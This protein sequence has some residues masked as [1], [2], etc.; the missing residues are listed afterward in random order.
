MSG[1]DPYSARFW[2]LMAEDEEKEEEERRKK[3]GLSSSSAP[4]VSNVSNNELDPYSARFWEL[5]NEEEEK[6]QPF[7]SG[8]KSPKD[9]EEDDDG[10]LDF[11]DKGS[12]NIFGGIAATIGDVGLSATKGIL[13]L[14][15]GAGDLIGYGLA[16]I[17]DLFGADDWADEQREKAKKNTVEDGFKSMSD[18]LDKYSYLG[19]TSQAIAQGIGQVGGIILTGGLGSAAGLGAVGTTALTTGVMGATSMGSGMSEAY[20][21]GA[22]DEDALKYGVIKGFVD[23]GTELIFGGLGKTVKAVGLSKG[24]SSLD[25]VFARKLSEKVAN[26]TAKQF[27]QF[28]VK[29][30]AEGVEEVLAGIGSAVGKKLTYADDEE[31]GQLLQDENLLEQFVV[32]A[33]T[34][35][36]AQS[37]YVPGMK[38]GSLRESF[39]TGRDFISGLSVNEQKVVDSVFEKELAEKEKSGK[40]T[41]KAKNKLYEQ[42]I[43]DMKLGR[44]SI[45]DIEGALGGESYNTYKT[46]SEQQ[47]KLTEQ[48]KALTEE[49]ESIRNKPNPTI[50]DSERLAEARAEQAK[51]Q[52]QLKELGVK[53]QDFKTKL[54]ETVDTLTQS[55]TYLRESYNERAKRRQKFEADVSK[56]DAKQQAAVQRAI[57][58]GILNNTRR[59]HEIVDLIAK[60]EAD[61]GVSFDFANN[62]KLKELGFTIE[63]GVVNGVLTK[64]GV[65]LNMNSSNVARSVIGHEITHVLQGTEL[66]SELQKAIKQYA[67]TKGV[68]DSRY[69]ELLELYTKKDAD[70]KIVTDENGNTIYLTKDG[71]IEGIENEVVADLVGEYLFTDTDFINEL[72][73]KHRN[74]FQKIYDE[75]KYLL[76]VI[77]AGS[78]EAR[79]LEKVKHAFD[80]AYKADVKASESNGV[81]FSFGVTQNDINNYVDSAYDNK[82]S[83]DYK[84]YAKVSDRLLNDVAEEIDLNGYSHALRD[85]DIRHIRNSHGENTAEKY[86][87]TKE[88]IKNIPWIVENYDKAVVVKRNDG[89]VGIIYVKSAENG[90]VY[91][92][93]Q[94]TSVYGNEP[95]LVNKQMI[96]TGIDDIPDLPGLKEA[97]TKKQSEIEFLDDLK[98][99]PKVYAQDVY[100]SHSDNKIAQQEENV[101]TDTSGDVQFSLSKPVEKTKNLVALHNLTQEK[102]LKS[103]DVGGL[104]M[105]SIAVT[106]SDIPHDNFGE[107][108]LIFG[109]DTVDP[110]ANKKNVVYSADAWTPTF[111]QVEYEAD[112]NVES[113]INNKINDLKTRVDDIF[114][115]DLNRLKYNYEYNLNR[116]G[117]EEG[118][119][120]NAMENYGLKAAYLEEQGQHIDKVTKQIEV[121]KG[122]SSANEAKYQAIAD[123]LGT[124]SAEEIGKLPFDEVREKYGA[125]LEDIYPGMT[126]SNIRISG[127]FNQVMAYLNN[128]NSGPVYKT[129]TDE[130]AMRKAVDD[131]LDAD[132]FE[133]WTRNLFSGI[134]KDSGIYNQKDLFTPSGNRRSFKQTH[135]PFT[136]ENIVKAMA[137][138]NNG[139][140]KNVAGFNGIKS[141]RAGTAERFKSI[142]AMHKSEGRLQHLTQEEADK[143]N[144]DLSSRLYNII[145]TIDN[146]NGNLGESNSFIRFDTIGEILMEIS[147]SGKY[148]VADIQQG[149]A[150]YRREISDNTAADI[151]QLLYDVSQMPVNIYEAK[152]ERAVSFDEAKV[153]VI[154]YNAD[155][156]LK[157]ELLNRG[158]SIAEYDPNVEGDRQKV[159]NSF[160]EYKFSLSNVGEKPRGRETLLSD[161]LLETDEDL[162]PVREIEPETD[163]SP[164]G[165]KDLPIADD[166][167][168]DDYAPLSDQEVSDREREFFENI[169]DEDAPEEIAP[170]Y[171]SEPDEIKIDNKSLKQLSKPISDSLGQNKAGRRELEQLIQEFSSGKYTTK[172]QLYE[173]VDKRFGTAYVEER[174]EEIAEAKD[175]IRRTPIFVSPTV[176]SD[177]N[178]K[179]GYQEFMRKNFGKLRFSK[180][181]NSL[182]VDSF[183][184]ELSE[185]YPHLFPADVVVAADQLKE[186]ARVAGLPTKDIMPIPVGEEVIQ[187]ATD[188]IYDSVR[189]YQE[190]ERLS[191]AL[192]EQHFP[193]DDS[194]VPPV[195]DEDMGPVAEKLE[196]SDGVIGE[197]PIIS[198]SAEVPKLRDPNEP[199]KTVKERTEEQLR[200]YQTELE[201]NRK[202]REE[203][204]KDFDQEI[205]RMYAEYNALKNKN[206][207]KANALLQSIERKKRVKGNTDASYE[208][209][210]SDLEAKVEKM[211]SQEFQTATQRKTV[212]EELEAEMVELLG[213]TT[214][215]K[216]KKFGLSYKSNTYKRNLE[217]IVRDENGQPDIQRARAIYEATQGRYNHNEAGMNRELTRLRKK[218]ADMKINS[219]EDIYIQ[220][221]GEF[222]HN[223]ETTLTEDFVK[224]YYE[225]NKNKI[226]TIKVDRA[227]EL[228]RETYDSL[229]ERVNAV[230]RA[231]GKKE[232]PYRKG[233]FPHYMDEKQGPLAKLFNWKTHDNEIPTSIA[234]LTEDFKPDRSWQSFNKERTSDV[235]T[236]GFQHGFDAYSFGALDWIYHIEDIQR[237][238]ALENHIRYTHSEEG[239]KKRIDQINANEE[240]DADE[241]QRQID[242]V[243]A[244]A[245]NPLNNFVTDLRAHTNR[246]AGKKSSLD[247]TMEETTNRKAYNVMNNIS[248]RVTANMVVGSVS[249]ALTNFI[250]ITQS[251]GEV[252]P[253][254]SLRAMA[255]TIRS[256]FRDDGTINKSDFLTNR[257]RQPEDLQRTTWDKVIDKVSILMEAIDSFTSQT[258]WRS[259]YLENIANGMSEVE[260]IKSADQFAENVIGGRSRG[261]MPT[262]F[263]SKNP[264]TKAFTAFQLEVANQYNYM[265]KDLPRD[266][267]G[268]RIGN[269]I[270]GYASIFIGAYVYN[271]VYSSLVG[272]NVAFD[273][274][275]IVSELLKDL[276]GDDEE[277]DEKKISNAITN[278][279]ENVLQQV[280]FVGGLLGGGRVPISSALPYESL[281][282]MI[283]ELPKDISDG[284][285][286][287]IIKEFLNPLVYLGLP[288][289]GG[290]IKKTVQGLNMF[291]DDLPVSGSYTDS[292]NLRFPVEDTLANRIQAG[293]FGQ[294]ASGNAQEYFDEER[295]PLKPNQIEEF[296]AL[297]IPISD[298]W[299]IRDGLK[300]LKTLEEKFEYVNGLDLPDEKKNILINNI[301]DREEEVDIS[302]YDEYAD[303]EEFDFAIKNEEKYA[304]LQENNI[305]YSDY[306]ASEESRD[307]YNWAF[308]NPEKYTLSKVVVDDVVE[309]RRYTK[310]LNE[311][312][313]DVDEDGNTIS[314]SKK[315]KTIDWINNLDLEYGK[316]IILF[317]SRYKADDTY[318]YDIIE[319]L[320][321]RKDISYQDAVT[322][323]T[324]LGFTV[325]EDD[326]ITWD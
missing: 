9:E 103:L 291:D 300:G 85:N 108:T 224:E 61:K 208:K 80:K 190:T 140:T 192:E 35:G 149:F 285:K 293:L 303:Y 79:Q 314:G 134:V 221:L 138:Q 201:Q 96:K 18:Y 279:A 162:G 308:S 311:L 72:S 65:S 167:Y 324:E 117:G 29:A 248:S 32:G 83:E 232:I 244:E 68:Y 59:T 104:P 186:I 130:A 166:L 69:N 89:K 1:L 23:A 7:D 274:I 120:K 169:T 294:W 14:V 135:L 170:I 256:T 262:L 129:V 257:L 111:P 292:G 128:Q 281:P 197:A 259:K 77:S 91:Y 107:I 199:I 270:K 62:A 155:A 296:A 147:E 158:F 235:T 184:M 42:V 143:I 109:K 159:V 249:A 10:G 99:A 200:N 216:D 247:R 4:S 87:V 173:E 161:M 250:P 2:E 261:N 230:L 269:L 156:K 45:D 81:L 145:E 3:L 317:K 299:D 260:A 127:I 286:E 325:H 277:D 196:S 118:L 82:N 8:Y 47:T 66:Y 148:N 211:S 60:L 78:K 284:N 55:D 63:G 278:T 245:N 239:V 189:E 41:N 100:Q 289:G 218:F 22:S 36:I 255:D 174:N 6:K 275:R 212:Q 30:S 43:E 263:E 323:L 101:N 178:G 191:I 5:M 234:G 282:E 133:A 106:K 203:A 119:V 319:Y 313:A 33:V 38:N 222:R 16:G 318:N 114:N 231:R 229:F 131:A 243:Y 40:L 320:N 238:R 205:A 27:I 139:N 307:A 215:W 236:Y 165:V 213:V 272:R 228:A 49:I 26:Q 187:D 306:N 264:L 175:F 153:F 252:S 276:L 225:K 273:P 141:L 253:I 110:K 305:S 171:D 183:Y 74:V 86:P 70:G 194:L 202:L 105:P 124:N 241:T 51:I 121:D 163:I 297:D 312:K 71:K 132:G 113:R 209:R 266:V 223:P 207:Q 39:S 254:S 20:Q 316:K 168:P 37:G 44:V 75:I 24:I 88:D 126:K 204:Q 28:G 94:V 67:T 54:S 302:D 46:T 283:K 11:F 116:Y 179:N 214:Y 50:A 52:E 220:M 15:E 258:V 76:K 304:F 97:I 195:F 172:E 181:V 53:T 180:D 13:G 146:E 240:L 326:T 280:P 112:I 123:I 17:A 217:D 58:S 64:N 93:E 125:M 227:I 31:L 115:D 34:S 48:N 271:E 160:E 25:D 188:L 176:K 21:S 309:Y 310:S 144:D 151:K 219:A 206:T 226:D 315:E 157:Q 122:F 98:K 265:F 298:Y 177:F 288:V 251:W 237:F 267:K 295:S 242:A 95:L 90:L 290:Q 193:L 322:I 321:E 150:Q 164:I 102:L 233:Y 92:L 56:Y 73:T 198:E 152:P 210:I 12:S 136:L 57:D 301:V 185:Q 84:K 142:E 19:D 287:K 268:N 246:L 182:P 137:A 154:P